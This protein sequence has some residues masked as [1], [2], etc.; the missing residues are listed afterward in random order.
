[1]V[2]VLIKKRNSRPGRLARGARLLVNAVALGL[3]LLV[4]ARALGRGPEGAS[5]LSPLA[6][7]ALE[8]KIQVL[9]NSGAGAGG[10]QPI[11]ISDLEANS[12]LKYRGRD[13]LPPGVSDP[14]V[15]IHPDR[16]SGA[17]EVDFNQLNQTGVKTDDWSAKLLAML[18]TGKQHVAADGKLES[19]N[20]QATLKIEDVQLGNTTLPDW[21]AAALLDNYVQKRYH[22]DLSKPLLLPDHV[23]RIELGDSRATFH[24]SPGKQSAPGSPQ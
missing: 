12:Y 9:A 20:G 10:S 3:G 16:V 18:V 17:A 4:W 24:R 21:L 15:H 7:R 6:A 2:N 1:M 19:A 22:I 14:Q 5:E 8:E 23:T 13:F 11:V